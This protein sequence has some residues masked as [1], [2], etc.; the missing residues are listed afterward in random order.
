[1]ISFA[2]EVELAEEIAFEVLAKTRS[3]EDLR[4]I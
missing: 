3:L 2:V 4:R 1:M